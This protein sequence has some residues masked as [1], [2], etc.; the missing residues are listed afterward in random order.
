MSRETVRLRRELLPQLLPELVAPDVL[1]DY[2]ALLAVADAA[3]ALLK[4]Y[5]RVNRG[6]TYFPELRAALAAL[7]AL[8]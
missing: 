8:P 7:E 2:D 4:N 1:A 5:D 3:A 6:E